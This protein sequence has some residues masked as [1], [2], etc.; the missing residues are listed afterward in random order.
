VLAQRQQIR[1]SDLRQL[2]DRHHAQAK[3]PLPLA[4]LALALE[5][6][7]DVP[8]SQQA[9]QQALAIKPRAKGYAG[10]YGSEVRDLALTLVLANDSQLAQ[11]P[12][13]SIYT[14][15]D[16]LV[17]R[18]WLSTQEQFALYRLAKAFSSQPIVA[19][20]LQVKTAEQQ[21]LIHV[22]QAWHNHWQAES[23]PQ[24]LNLKNISSVPL[25]VEARVQGFP[26]QPPEPLEQG[27]RVSRQFY[28]R[29]GLE[30]DLNQV[31]SGEL[32]LV[33][34]E[35]QSISDDTIPEALLVDLL[36]AG[37]E[38]ENPNLV[39][40]VKL[41]EFSLQGKAVDEWQ[42]MTPINHREYRDD[43]FV[44]ALPLYRD[45][46]SH[47]FYLVRAVTPGMYR[48]PPTQVEDMYRPDI[49]V[50]GESPASVTVL[51]K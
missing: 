11:D 34:L 7:G 40:S 23:I 28:N 30:V 51:P 20:K 17:Q 13:R 49:R 12:W 39:T 22:K 15:R 33:H 3:S 43:R 38:L 46:V 27:I 35:V 24:Q 26:A 18:R 41:S 9:W 10:D 14:L 42:A 37:F 44:A 36:P 4:Q 48:L 47:L 32:L 19:W 21:A 16:Q 29:Q 6:A 50:I 25:F 8:R 1:L 31:T 2:F 5:L 45:Q